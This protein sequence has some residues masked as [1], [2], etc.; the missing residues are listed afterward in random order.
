MKKKAVSRRRQS[1]IRAEYDFRGGTRGK[2][3]SSVARETNVVVLDPD[4]A[5]V[6][7]D[8]DSVNE[9]LRVLVKVAR[10]TRRRKAS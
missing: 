2:Y 4:V 7:R 3:A 5:S 10:S 9:A 8:S 1:D 6:F